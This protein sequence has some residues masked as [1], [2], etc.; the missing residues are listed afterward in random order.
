MVIIGKELP[1]PSKVLKR[2]V[3]K[4]GKDP[5]FVAPKT[6]ATSDAKTKATGKGGTA[7]ALGHP[8]VDR[9]DT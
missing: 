2:N 9:P 5:V 7:V 1:G 6:N 4:V 8:A 3:E